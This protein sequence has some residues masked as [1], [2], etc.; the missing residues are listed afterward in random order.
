MI[1]ELAQYAHYTQDTFHSHHYLY[2]QSEAIFWENGHLFLPDI[3]VNADGSLRHLPCLTPYINIH[4]VPRDTDNNQDR[5]R[6]FQGAFEYLQFLN[7]WETDP[8][9]NSKDLVIGNTNERMA[10]FAQKHLGFHLVDKNR[11]G[12]LGII[13]NGG[14]VDGV[15]NTVFGLRDELMQYEGNVLSILKIL[16]KQEKK[17]AR[18][19]QDEEKRESALQA[20][21]RMF[22]ILNGEI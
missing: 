4:F 18:S 15:Q 16:I 22:S 21:D 11:Q 3:V 9:R 17:S 6:M 19:I 1:K 13:A 2:P 14:I 20:L 10:N 12:G 7:S 8:S 5:F